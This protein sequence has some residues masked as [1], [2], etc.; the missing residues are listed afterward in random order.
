MTYEL[1]ISESSLANFKEAIAAKFESVKERVQLS[2]AEKFFEIVKGNFGDFGIDRPIAWAPLSKAYSKKM[3]R[4]NATLFVTGKLQSSIKMESS[5][6]CGKV[7]VSDGDCAYALVH[8]FGSAPGVIGRSGRGKITDTNVK[9]GGHTTPARPYFPIDESGNI[10][11][12]TQ[13]QV[14]EAAR[15][16]LQRL[17]GGTTL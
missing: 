10:T 11:A 5:P 17:I 1:S 14:E 16:E 13:A 7:S 15:E 6:D 8:Q 4:A 2:M 12:Y 9:S 3:G